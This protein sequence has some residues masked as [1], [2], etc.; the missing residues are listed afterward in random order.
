VVDA[1]ASHRPY[2]AAL[3]LVAAVSEIVDHPEKFDAQVLAAF[4]R[5]H[6]QG[7]IDL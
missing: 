2:R 3:G 6:E 1:M 7:R 4:M 5:L